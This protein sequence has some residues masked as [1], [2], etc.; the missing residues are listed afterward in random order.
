MGKRVDQ[1]L[2]ERVRLIDPQAE[3]WADDSERYHL[4]RYLHLDEDFARLTVREIG[5][6]GSNRAE[7]IAALNR[8]YGLSLDPKRE[9]VSNDAK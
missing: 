2:T 8:R 6:L 9:E 4:R 5:M 3:I 7:A 1:E